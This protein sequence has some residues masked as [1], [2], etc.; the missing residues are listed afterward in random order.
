MKNQ[1]ED[2]DRRQQEMLEAL[3]AET[4]VRRAD[5]ANAWRPGIAGKALFSSQGGA[6]RNCFQSHL[7]VRV[8][9]TLTNEAH[10]CSVFGKSES[11]P[12]ISR[13]V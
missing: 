12:D 2:E 7:F 10:L 3:E 13:L 1:S 8:P 6:A 5:I 4:E 11:G 9:S